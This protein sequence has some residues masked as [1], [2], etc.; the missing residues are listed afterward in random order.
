[1]VR[2]RR[3]FVAGGTFFFTVTL[4][5]RRSSALTDNSDVLRETFQRTRDRQP[6]KIDAIVVLPD[7]LHAIWT[8]PDGDFD[9][10]G[11]WRSIKAGMT[12]DLVKRGHAASRNSK[13]E[14]DIWQRRFWEHTVRDESDL[15][16]CANYIHFNPVK[17]G[18]VSVPVQWPF[19]SFHRYVREKLLPPDWASN[20]EMRG[21][22]FGERIDDE[23]YAPDCASLHPG[24]DLRSEN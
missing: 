18:L 19:S 13:G 10:S 24:Y 5:N 20:S 14:Y 9:F 12:R 6:F 8:L 23:L 15:E 4:K 11:R 22:D 7:H 17:H 16:R 2:Y 21:G 1:M 3:N